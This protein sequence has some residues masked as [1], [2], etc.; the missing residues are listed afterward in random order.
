MIVQFDHIT[1]ACGR[2][3]LEETINNFSSYEQ[4]FH[5]KNLL[6]IEAKKKLL[7]SDLGSHDI[8]LLR[9]PNG[10]VSVEI[11]AY[12]S[13]DGIGKY[14]INNKYI[15][16]YTNRNKICESFNFYS[17]LGFK[18]DLN[19]FIEINPLIGVTPVRFNLIETKDMYDY[20]LDNRGYCCISL[21][22]NNAMKEKKRID[23][24]GI[25]TT[26]INQ[27]RVQ[28]KIFDIFFAYNNIGDTVEFISPHSSK[29]VQ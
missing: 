18:Y 8:I 27:L 25:T 12:D 22:T 2:D 14:D 5:E 11:T 20:Y 19:G 24:K 7:M 23:A 15:Y 28:G 13:V 3:E 10:G 26:E 1:F 4:V 29:D 21:V 17:A 6:N 16:I 9:D